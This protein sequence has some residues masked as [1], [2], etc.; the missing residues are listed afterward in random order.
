L[1]AVADDV[2]ATDPLLRDALAA[3]GAIALAALLEHPLT[4]DVARFAL[5]AESAALRHR[6][7]TSWS[8]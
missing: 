7:G 2:A 6:V 5:T 4:G 1:L 8:R 3:P